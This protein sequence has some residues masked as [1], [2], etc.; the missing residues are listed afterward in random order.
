MNLINWIFIGLLL[1]DLLLIVISLIKKIN[2]MQKICSA[3]FLPFTLMH[4]PLLLGEYLPDSFR[5]IFFSIL[6][7]T[8]IS[9]SFCIYVFWGNNFI[10][11]ILFSIGNACWCELFRSVFYIYRMPLWA[12]TIII[13]LYIALAITSLIITGQKKKSEYFIIILSMSFASMLNFFGV[14][15]LFCNPCA[16]SAILF[17]GSFLNL[18]FLVLSLIDS[19]KFKIKNGMLIRTIALSASQFLISLSNLMLF[20]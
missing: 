19:K 20:L 18:L 17:S 11:L 13:A 14:F 3:L 7:L 12:I 9:I 5:V 1:V 10:P 8:F 16:K 15:N 4:V 2:L 6:A